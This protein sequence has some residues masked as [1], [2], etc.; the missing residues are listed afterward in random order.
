MTFEEL[1]SA[2]MDKFQQFG[3]AGMY[4]PNEK[5]EPTDYIVQD[6]QELLDECED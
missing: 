3:D 1:K 4:K 5:L 6:I 2:I